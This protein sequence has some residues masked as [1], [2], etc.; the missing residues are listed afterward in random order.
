MIIGTAAIEFYIPQSHS[1]KDK[2][3]VLKSIIARV[4]NKFNVSAAEIDLHELWG[5]ALV[6]IAC[7]SNDTRYANQVLSQIINMVENEITE[8]EM[9]S[10]GIEIW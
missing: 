4:S 6:G 8:A 5:R 9:V 1:L 3:R 7:V 10:H 2:R